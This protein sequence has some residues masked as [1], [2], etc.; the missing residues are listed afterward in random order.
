MVTNF[1]HTK[2]KSAGSSKRDKIS[3]LS[4]ENVF[5]RIGATYSIY[6]AAQAIDG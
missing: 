2:N 1:G 3:S 4:F 6:I 5:Y